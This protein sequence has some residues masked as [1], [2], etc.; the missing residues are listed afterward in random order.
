MRLVRPAEG[1]H[2]GGSQSQECWAESPVRWAVFSS[3]ILHYL[4]THPIPLPPSPMIDSVEALSHG[5]DARK[6]NVWGR[7]V[8]VRSRKVVGF[9]QWAQAQLDSPA[10]WE[11]GTIHEI[12]S[13]DPLRTRNLRGRNPRSRGASVHDGKNKSPCRLSR[14][15]GLRPR[16][17]R[18]PDGPPQASPQ[19]LTIIAM[20]H[21]TGRPAVY[22]RKQF[23]RGGVP[24]GKLRSEV[25]VDQANSAKIAVVP[26]RNK[27]NAWHRLPYDS[28]TVLH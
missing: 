1:I 23:A 24:S 3:S 28:P 22:A 9:A 25:G 5:G 27:M 10:I 17:H 19:L 20:S 6:P 8:D 13:P 14:R 12:L 16:T 7:P 21:D 18:P 11:G 4:E 26:K 2:F 15:R